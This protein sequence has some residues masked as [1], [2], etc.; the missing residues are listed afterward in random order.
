MDGINNRCVGA[1]PADAKVFELLDQRAFGVAGGWPREHL[2][3]MSGL[4]RQGLAAVHCW[5]Q[6]GF[7]LAAT[8]DLEEAVEDNNLA[9]GLKLER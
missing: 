7:L 4:E 6:R 2:A 5:Q 9:F 1:W 3:G 8:I